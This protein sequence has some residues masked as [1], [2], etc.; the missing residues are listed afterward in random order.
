[1]ITGMEPETPEQ[2]PPTGDTPTDPAGEVPPPPPPPPPPGAGPEPAGG[3]GG[4]FAPPFQFLRSRHDRKVGG[5]AGGLAAA[6]GL[7]PTI[8]RLAIVLG[9]LTGWGVLAYL[10]A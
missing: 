6:A 9:L 2:S 5:V 10:I 1:M 4:V 7:D 8:V 3:G